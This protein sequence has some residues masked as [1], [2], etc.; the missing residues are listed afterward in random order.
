MKLGPVTKLYKKNNNK[1]L[2]IESTRKNV[3]SLSLFQFMANLE[4]SGSRI[5]D[6]ESAKFMF[7]LIVAF[8][9][10]KTENRTKISLTQLSQYCF[11]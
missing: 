4:Q 1:N 8:Y 6:A 7:P 2:K 5:T 11:E 9:F 10:T 3:T